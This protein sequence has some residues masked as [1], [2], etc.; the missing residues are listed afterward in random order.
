M[1]KREN[2]NEHPK[3]PDS[4]KMDE[5]SYPHVRQASDTKAKL[6]VKAYRPQ[7]DGKPV[8][9]TKVQHPH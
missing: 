8:F 7:D 9:M 4:A 5:L 3:K 1:N 6:S 2:W